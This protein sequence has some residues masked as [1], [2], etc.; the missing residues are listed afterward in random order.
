M[1]Y[2]EITITKNSKQNKITK[3][4]DFLEY[5]GIDLKLA[6]PVNRSKLKEKID[7]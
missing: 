7:V 4:R 6:N 3:L 2:G 1:N 5:R